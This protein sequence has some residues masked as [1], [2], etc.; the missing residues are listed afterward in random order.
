MQENYTFVCRNCKELCCIDVNC[1][2]YCTVFYR[3]YSMQWEAA[4]LHRVPHTT[5][6]G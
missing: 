5:V 3:V 1:N 4:I 6:I 2:I